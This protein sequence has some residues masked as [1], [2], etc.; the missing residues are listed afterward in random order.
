MATEA[1]RYAKHCNYAPL[2]KRSTVLANRGEHTLSICIDGVTLIG[3]MALSRIWQ[4][5][6]AALTMAI[7]L[8]LD[9]SVPLCAVSDMDWQYADTNRRE[10]LVRNCER[11]WLCLYNRD[12]A[13]VYSQS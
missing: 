7:E 9:A 1:W 8:R 13:Y 2:R 12:R 3:I 6:G 4:Q 10:R 11:T 5:L